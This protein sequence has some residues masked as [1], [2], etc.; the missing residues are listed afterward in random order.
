MV[1]W[2]GGRV[3]RWDRGM[4]VCDCGGKGF[5]ELSLCSRL[6]RREGEGKEQEKYGGYI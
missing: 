1:R 2:S 3:V 5:D 6:M 4:M